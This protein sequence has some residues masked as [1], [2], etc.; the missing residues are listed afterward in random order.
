MSH[1]KKSRFQDIPV[2][3]R[4]ERQSQLISK[5]EAGPRGRVPINLRIWMRNPDFVD[6]V[7]PFGLYVSNTAPITKRQKEIA[8]LVGA[9]FWEA[10]LE[11][12]VHQGHAKKVGITAEQIEAIGNGVSPNFP[13]ET[14]NLTYELAVAFHGKGRV[15]DELHARAMERLGH[16]GVSDLIG[17]IG[18][19]TM[20]SMTLNFYDVSPPSTIEPGSTID[21]P[22]KRS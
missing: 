19:Y 14:E 2:E 13:D 7:E 15:P 18:L 6:A 5:I 12:H 22:R 10:E 3:E 21:F 1:S 4:T 17:L 9:S 11:W 16:K 20:I 8:V